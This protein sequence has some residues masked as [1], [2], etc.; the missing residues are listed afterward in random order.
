MVKKA[1]WWLDST[2]ADQCGQNPVHESSTFASFDGTRPSS[3]PYAQKAS[4][5]QKKVIFSGK[6]WYKK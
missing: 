5:Y 1:E 4:D 3:W 2:T 6:K